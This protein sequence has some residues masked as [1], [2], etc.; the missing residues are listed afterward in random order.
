MASPHPACARSPGAR[1]PPIRCP[2]CAPN[3]VKHRSSDGTSVITTCEIC[4]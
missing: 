1:S 2:L 3:P 4:A